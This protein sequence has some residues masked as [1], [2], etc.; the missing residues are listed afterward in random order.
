[1]EM[2]VLP[3][4]VSGAMEHTGTGPLLFCSDITSE[5]V[6]HIVHQPLVVINNLVLLSATSVPGGTP[7][8]KL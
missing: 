7:I 1:M 6:L 8:Y 4:P 2:Q 5:I 3:H